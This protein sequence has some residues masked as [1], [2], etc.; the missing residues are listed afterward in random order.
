MSPK[1]IFMIISGLLVLTGLFFFAFTEIITKQVFPEFNAYAM[2]FGI[3]MRYIL[4]PSILA[5][6]CIFLS[7]EYCRRAERQANIVGDGSRVYRN[8]YNFTVC[9]IYR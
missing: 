2:N 5:I 8:F 4:A 3:V 6:G 1:L 7:T 9:E